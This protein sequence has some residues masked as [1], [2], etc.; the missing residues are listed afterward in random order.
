MRP[1]GTDTGDLAGDTD[2]IGGD[3]DAGSFD[4]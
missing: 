4:I 2:D 3:F 1:G